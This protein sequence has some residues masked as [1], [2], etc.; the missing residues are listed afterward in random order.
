MKTTD[1]DPGAWTRRYFLER[2]GAVGGS[3][4]LMSAMRSW[5]LMAQDV[6]S[7]PRLAGRGGGKS[8]I[9]TRRGRVGA[10]DVL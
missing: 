10:H 6:E 7:R 8:V 5:D 2:F 3:A 1:V 4:V 9:G